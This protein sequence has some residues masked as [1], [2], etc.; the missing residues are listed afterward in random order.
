MVS[1]KR[2]HEREIAAYDGVELVV[3]P[4]NLD[5]GPGLLLPLV[6]VL[7]RDPDGRVAFLPSDHHVADAAPF[8]AAL[9][10]PRAQLTLLGVTPTGPEVEYG[11]ILCGQRLACGRAHRVDRFHEKPEQAVA[12]QLFER[13]ALWNTFISTGHV[14]HYWALARQYLPVHTALFERYATSIGSLEE[15]L[16]LARAYELMEPANFSRNLLTHARDLAVVPVSGSGWSDWGSPRRVFESLAGTP[17]LDL[18][19]ARIREPRPLAL[20][21]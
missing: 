19:L 20:A 7:A 6:R 12:E 1:T 4:R 14:Q 17:E 3:Q 11:S 16:A 5:T 8:I 13:G 2:S 15:P 21:S 9:E 10:E 18:L